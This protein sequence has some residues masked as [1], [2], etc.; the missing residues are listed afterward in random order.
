[1]IDNG[2]AYTKYQLDLKPGDVYWNTAVVV[3]QPDELRGAVPVAFV[4][5][6]TGHAPTERSAGPTQALRTATF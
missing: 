6:E 3:G 4:T 5:L 2:H 1:V